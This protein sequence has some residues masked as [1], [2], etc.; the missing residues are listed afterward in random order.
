MSAA[1]A[2]RVLVAPDKFKGSLSAPLVA[3]AV[4]VGLRRAVPGAD[5]DCVP[6]ADGGDGT[7]DAAVASGFER[8][9]VTASGPT[10]RPVRTAY[11]RR[12]ATAVIEMADVCGLARLPG[13]TPA[14]LTA[15]SRG[16]GEVMA[17]ALDAGCRDLVVG[18]GGSASTDGGLGV[19]CALGARDDGDRLELDG[20]HPAL[21]E[22]RVVV[23][24]DVDN[25]LTG[26]DGAAPVYA[27]QKGASVDDVARLDVRLVRW[28]DRVAVATRADRRDEPGAGAA[29]GVGFG[30]VAVLGA[31]LRPGIALM[32]DLLGFD[33]RVRGASL[34]VTGEGSLDAQSL[35]GKA[36]VGVS[37]AAGRAG[38]PV[39][40]VCGRNLL[41]TEQL[42]A[43]GIRAAYALTEVEPDVDICLREPAR[44]LADLGERIARDHLAWQCG[45]GAPGAPRSPH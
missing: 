40:A 20:L 32:L 8:V 7:L 15:S 25:P 43:A 29:G 11:A 4:A 19:L 13:G 5:V 18:I 10:G 37:A 38:A 31:E 12:G 45:A 21:A 9:P 35:R 30:L 28:A 24:C 17:H 33:D 41:S 16:L 23:A 14:P 2:P 6:V 22:S 44:L 3:E 42:A 39:V 27:P 26:P 36:P 1:R 34:V